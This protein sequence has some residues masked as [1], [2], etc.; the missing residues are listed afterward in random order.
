MDRINVPS[1]RLKPEN[2]EIAFMLPRYEMRE[3]SKELAAFLP[4]TADDINDRL[5]EF[6]KDLFTECRSKHDA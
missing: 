5:T 4:L 3:L 1:E 2:I 6:C